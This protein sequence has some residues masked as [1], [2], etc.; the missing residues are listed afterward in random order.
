MKATL[1]PHDFE[2]MWRSPVKRPCLQDLCGAGLVL[3]TWEDSGED[4][5]RLEWPQR[6]TP[7]QK[8]MEKHSTLK[9]LSFEGFSTGFTIYMSRGGVT[10]SWVA[11]SSLVPWSEVGR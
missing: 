9:N 7:R 1:S 5:G 6:S 8:A 10:V 3:A 11:T 2:H 4:S